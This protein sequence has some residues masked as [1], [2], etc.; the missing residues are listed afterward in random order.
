MYKPGSRPTI[1]GSQPAPAQS[2]A[3]TSSNSD[4]DFLQTKNAET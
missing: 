1:E 2:A 3:E 4:D